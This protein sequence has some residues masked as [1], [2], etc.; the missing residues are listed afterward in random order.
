MKNKYYIVTLFFMFLG[1]KAFSQYHVVK[2]TDSLDAYPKAKGFFYALPKNYII[3]EVK[4]IKTNKYKGPFS[5]YAETLQGLNAIQ[6]SS[7]QY[8]IKEMNLSL[9][10]QP[11]LSEL[12][13]VSYPKKIKNIDYYQFIKNGLALNSKEYYNVKETTG[14]QIK[15]S[16]P[17]K[18]EEAQ[19]EMY[20]KYSMYEKIDTTYE[21]KFIDSA[22]I[23]IPQIHKKMVVKTTE[24]K[25]KEALDE[26]KAIRDAQWL[27][28]TGEH[29]VNFSNLEFMISSLK[30]KEQIYLSLFSGFSTTETIEY[31]FYFDIP[32]KADTINIPLF[33]FTSTNGIQQETQEYLDMYSLQLLNTNYTTNMQTFLKNTP[34][35]KKTSFYYRIPEYYQLSFYLNDTKL[36]QV[37]TLPINQYGIV[38]VLPSNLTSF[39]INSQTGNVSNIVFK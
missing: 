5:D 27:L 10:Y 19:F 24:E 2:V 3:V 17:N 28:L 13:F 15:F 1:I 7:T 11:D 12:F 4:V 20:N 35:Q 22:Y 37:G 34:N 18:E 29:E 26:I 23:H 21:T 32:E 6:E 38:D 9:G 30:E 31:I 8:T 33:S 39:E 25:A 36:K 14:M 16:Y